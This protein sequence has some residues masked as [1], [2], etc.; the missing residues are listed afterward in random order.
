M[1]TWPQRRVALAATLVS[2]LLWAELRNNSVYTVR[3]LLLLCGREMLV[4]IRTF[5][6]VLCN[7]LLRL[8]LRSYWGFSN[9][10]YSDGVVRFILLDFHSSWWYWWCPCFV[11]CSAVY[12]TSPT[13][14]CTVHTSL[15]SFWTGFCCPASVAVYLL[16]A[17]P[18][19]DSPYSVPCSV[20]LVFLCCSS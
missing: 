14:Y 18:R 13:T 5:F 12:L 4:L 8:E 10:L 6:H 9:T 16:L 15:T 2:V 1:N 20:A 11:Q 7:T 17:W 3:Y 19:V